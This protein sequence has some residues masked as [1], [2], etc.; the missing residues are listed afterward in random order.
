[1]TPSLARVVPS[2]ALV[3]KV[4]PD[5]SLSS[6]SHHFVDTSVLALTH[7]ILNVK[8]SSLTT[9]HNRF[10]NCQQASFIFI[11]IIVPSPVFDGVG[12]KEMC[13]DLLSEMGVHIES[14]M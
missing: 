4:F 11:Q 9:N 13:I 6:T 1:M 2:A 12:A 8:C 7:L 3:L 10:E 14:S 5:L